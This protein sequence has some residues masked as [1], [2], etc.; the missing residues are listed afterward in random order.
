MNQLITGIAMFAQRL[1]VTM[2]RNL[3]KDYRF[4]VK[5]NQDDSLDAVELFLQRHRASSR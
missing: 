4:Q 2:I 1:L 5:G 3:E